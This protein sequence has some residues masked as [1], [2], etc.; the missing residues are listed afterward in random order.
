MTR[1]LGLTNYLGHVKW[2]DKSRGVTAWPR[3]VS[4]GTMSVGANY[5]MAS[6]RIFA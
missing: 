4:E 3:A 2:I 6:S 5:M 1:I